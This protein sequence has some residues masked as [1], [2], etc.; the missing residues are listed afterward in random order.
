MVPKL[1]EFGIAS[2]QKLNGHQLFVSITV[3]STKHFKFQNCF[4]HQFRKIAFD[5]ELVKLTETLICANYVSSG[6]CDPE[7]WRSV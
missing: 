3:E 2:N 5:T 7:G 4:T 1:T 6:S